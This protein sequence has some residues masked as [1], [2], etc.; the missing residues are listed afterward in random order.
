MCVC[1]YNTTGHCGVY[2]KDF[3]NYKTDTNDMKN[4]K[5][6]N[7]ETLKVLGKITLS[8]SESGT[9]YIAPSSMMDGQVLLFKK[10]IGKQ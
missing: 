9:D 1:Q 10:N 6:D 2:C 5:I 4:C 7:D 3:G 8:L